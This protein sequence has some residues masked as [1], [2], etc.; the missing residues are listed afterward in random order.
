L[1]AISFF[2]TNFPFLLEREVERHVLR[3][4]R[5]R[6]RAVKCRVR[7]C[8][9]AQRGRGAEMWTAKAVNCSV[10]GPRAVLTASS[11]LLADRV[12]SWTPWTKQ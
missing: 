2:F 4:R 7:G 11:S 8:S 10:E 6:I 1:L 5:G 3:A 12:R 9:D